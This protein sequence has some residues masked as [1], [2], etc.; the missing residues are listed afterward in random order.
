[1]Q[2]DGGGDVGVGSVGGYTA[3]SMQK[4]TEKFVL[5][6]F[7]HPTLVLKF[8][9]LIFKSSLLGFGQQTQH[10]AKL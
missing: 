3:F 9:L 6:L 2:C 5:I 1:M 8:V 4:L 7:T 10:F